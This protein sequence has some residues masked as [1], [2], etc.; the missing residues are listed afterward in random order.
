MYVSAVSSPARFWVQLVGAQVAQLDDLV[1]H[2]TEYYNNKDNRANHAVS[3]V[4]FRE[5]VIQIEALGSVQMVCPTSLE[6][7]PI[8]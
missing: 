4:F 3:I 5:E 6:C 8:Q 2:M 7:I 1:E